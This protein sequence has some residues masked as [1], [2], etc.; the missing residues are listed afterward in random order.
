M[1]SV[2]NTPLST[3][4]KGK[5]GKNVIVKNIRQLIKAICYEVLYYPLK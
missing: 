5:G 4:N 2:S 3:E 1:Y